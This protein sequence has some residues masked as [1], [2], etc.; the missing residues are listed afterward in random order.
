M[1]SRIL[2]LAGLFSVMVAAACAPPP[3]EVARPDV[4]ITAVSP[5]ITTAHQLHGTVTNVGSVAGDFHLTFHHK[6]VPQQI[7]TADVI[8]VLPGQT[9]I[10]NAAIANLPTVVSL[11]DFELVAASA[12]SRPEL[13]SAPLTATVDSVGL[14]SPCDL[15]PYGPCFRRI[16]GTLVNAGEVTYTSVYIE[17]IG[18]NGYTGAGQVTRTAPGQ[19]AWSGLLASDGSST[20]QGVV[21][22]VP[23][24]GVMGCGGP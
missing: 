19:G 23:C 8:K 17:M 1:R 2:P 7:G 3:T 5:I 9:A 18:T 6:G 12:Q 16:K 11:A 21:R 13:A 22:V 20:L 4:T 15:L 10:W 24:L 14:P